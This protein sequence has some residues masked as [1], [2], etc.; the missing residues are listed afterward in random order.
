MVPQ[1]MWCD[2]AAFR[3]DP[4]PDPDPDP[5]LLILSVSS[6]SKDSGLSNRRRGC[7][8]R[9]GSCST[10][11]FAARARHR[12]GPY[13]RPRG[14]D[15]LGCDRS[16]R[17]CLPCVSPFSAVLPVKQRSGALTPRGVRSSARTNAGFNSLHCDRWLLF[18]GFFWKVRS[19]VGA[20]PV[21]NTGCPHGSGSTPAPSA[22]RRS[23]GPAE[24]RG[25]VM[26]A[27]RPGT[28]RRV[29]LIRDPE[30]VGSLPTACSSRDVAQE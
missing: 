27:E 15:S 29:I 12:R 14:C 23:S 4:D 25:R 1:G 2:S 18:D 16:A 30:V 9:H 8:S 5:S 28:G 13:P 7:N 21:S 24:R 22:N 20:T 3:V 26:Q 10:V 11:G 6:S 17:G 19:A